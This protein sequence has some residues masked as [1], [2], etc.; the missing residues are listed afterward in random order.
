MKLGEEEGKW[1]LSKSCVLRV[2]KAWVGENG[3]L[4]F[5]VMDLRGLPAKAWD[6]RF[7]DMVV[8]IEQR[9]FLV[10]FGRASFLDKESR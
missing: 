9:V 3:S 6:W 4:G 5:G 10:K 2:S 7:M 1:G 8:E